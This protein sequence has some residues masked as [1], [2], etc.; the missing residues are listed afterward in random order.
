[1]SDETIPMDRLA[2]TYR[3]IRTKIAELTQEYDTKVETLK[4][5]QDEV[6][7]AMKDQMKALGVTSVRTAEGT[8]VLSVKTRYN[9]QDWDSFKKFVV[10]QDAVDLLEKRIAQTN[11]AQFLEENPGVV[12]PGLNSSSEYDVSVRKPTK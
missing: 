11:M 6:K 8:V 12:P 5:A 10:E 2:K 9:T 4:A 1:M 3:K 7:N